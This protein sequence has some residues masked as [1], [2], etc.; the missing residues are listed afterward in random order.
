M[1]RIEYGGELRDC[2]L[3]LGEVVDLERACGKIGIG[4]IFQR[5]TLQQYKALEVYHTIRL[6]LVGGGMPDPEARE[7]VQEQF[8]LKPLSVN[9][10]TAYR[11]LL[12]LIA[13]Q[14]EGDRDD[15]SDE[16]NGDPARPID[17]DGILLS[18]VKLGLSPKDVRSIEFEDFLGLMRASGRS[19]AADAITED[20]F[21]AMKA[22]Y[23]EQHGARY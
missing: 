17:F 1:I 18:L 19:A 13:G 14:G 23:E 5:M 8:D 3:A 20:E 12:D 6:A 15:D 4:D 22:R 2:K 21:E 11:I 9:V 16:P 7:L 10:E